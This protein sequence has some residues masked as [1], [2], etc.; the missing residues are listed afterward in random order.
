MFGD[1]DDLAKG[2]KGESPKVKSGGSGGL[3]SDKEEEATED[4]IFSSSSAK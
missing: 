2:G 3:F 4:D 1:P